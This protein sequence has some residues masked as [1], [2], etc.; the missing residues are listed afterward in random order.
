MKTCLIQP[1][2]CMDFSQSDTYFEWEIEALGQCDASMDL[3][4]LPEYSNVPCLANTKEEMLESYH[5]Y[6]QRLLDK[7]S[8]TAKRCDA[9]VFV[10]CIYETPTGLRNTTVAFDRTGAIAGHYFKQHLVPSEMIYIHFRRN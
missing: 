4:V 6:S 1:A 7:A 9:V 2:Y 8:E 3:I 10:N 5:K